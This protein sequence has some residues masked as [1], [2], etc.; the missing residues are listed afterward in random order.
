M[1][2]VPMAAGSMTRSSVKSAE[3]A[4]EVLTFLGTTPSPVPA[5]VISRT[6]GLPKSS[7]Y[8][9]LNVMRDRGFVAH[10]SEEGT[11]GL[12]PVAHHIG[13]ALHKHD[14]MRRLAR[15]LMD[16]LT[17][18][19]GA[20]SMLAVRYGAEALV[21]ARVDPA[22]SLDRPGPSVGER[23]PAHATALGRA[24]LMDEN[25]AT[26]RSLFLI[27]DLP[28]LSP[29]GP[30]RPSDLLEVLAMSRARGFAVESGELVPQITTIAAPVFDHLGF[31]TGAVGLTYRIGPH[32]RSDGGSLSDAVCRA[33]AG[34]SVRLGYPQRESAS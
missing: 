32:D 6:V 20:P 33:A 30:R 31:V 14:A 22:N 4:L 11:W 10:Y 5:A 16:R 9:L 28:S 17:A 34:L 23:T 2:Q 13:S 12:G 18:V 26:V 21:I 3:R 8:H 25:E 29:R 7:T 15:T 1:A 27:G 19:T 24:L